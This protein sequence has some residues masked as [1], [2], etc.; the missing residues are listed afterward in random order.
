MFFP[1]K[2]F[3][4]KCG[5]GREEKNSLKVPSSMTGQTIFIYDFTYGNRTF[6]I[7]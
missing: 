2:D 3:G 6:P 4:E 7:G 1:S 5:G